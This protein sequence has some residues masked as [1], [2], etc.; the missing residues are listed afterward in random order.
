MH[1]IMNHIKWRHVV[2]VGILALCL[3]AAVFVRVREANQLQDKYLSGYDAYFYY[4]QAK[5]IVAEGRLPDR[6]YMQHSPVGL[7]LRGRAN[8][9]CYAIAYLYKVIRLFAPDISINY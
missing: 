1:L 3:V 4:R 2:P 6:D 9:N 5:T 7:N 8:L